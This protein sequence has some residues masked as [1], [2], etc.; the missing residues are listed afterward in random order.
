M[1]NLKG[2]SDIKILK[3]T[4]L[5]AR[6]WAVVVL[7][8]MRLAGRWVLG[9]CFSCFWM[10]SVSLLLFWVVISD[11]ISLASMPTLGAILVSTE[12][13]TVLASFG[14]RLRRRLSPGLRDLE[15]FLDRF[16]LLYFNL[17]LISVLVILVINEMKWLYLLFIIMASRARSRFRSP[18]LSWSWSVPS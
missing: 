5:A 9:S 13:N 8:G 12:V 7:I 14:E 4:A 11:A 6:I 15:R 17:I 3:F 18:S 2:L 1:P 10:I 16:E